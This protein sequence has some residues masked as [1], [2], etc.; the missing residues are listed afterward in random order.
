RDET[1]IR[2]AACSDQHSLLTELQPRAA[3]QDRE[4]C[5]VTVTPSDREEVCSV[6]VTPSDREEVCSVTVTPSDREEVCSVTVTPSDREEVC[7]VTA[8][9]S[10]RERQ[11]SGVS[12]DFS[13]TEKKPVNINSWRKKQ[14]GFYTL[15][16]YVWIIKSFVIICE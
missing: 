11:S 16:L 10:D 1:L 2:K 12:S 8:T 9:P 7:S 3:A 13:D 14:L 5:S 4:V 15:Y 6:T